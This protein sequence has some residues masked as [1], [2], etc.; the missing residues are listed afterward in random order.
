[1]SFLPQNGTGNTEPA[2]MNFIQMELE[3]PGVTARCVGSRH[4]RFGQR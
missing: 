1:M 2:F 3:P 4:D